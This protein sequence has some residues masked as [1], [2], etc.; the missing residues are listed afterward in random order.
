MNKDQIKALLALNEEQISLL[1][2]WNDLKNRMEKANMMFLIGYDGNNN[3]IPA[4]INTA[5]INEIASPTYLHDE[6]ALVGFVKIDTN[7]MSRTNKYLP[8]GN[9]SFPK[10]EI[11][12]EDDDFYIRFKD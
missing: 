4:A 9:F 3:I 7:E 8:F 11:L 6:Q 12:L 10:T 2:E 1:E 5:N